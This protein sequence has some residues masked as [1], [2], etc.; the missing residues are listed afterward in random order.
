MGHTWSMLKLSTQLVYSTYCL[1]KMTQAQSTSQACN[2]LAADDLAGHLWCRVLWNFLVH[3]HFDCSSSPRGPLHGL[4]WNIPASPHFSFSCSATVPSVW[5]DLG[6]LLLRMTSA[7]P[8]HQRVS[9]MGPPGYASDSFSQSAKGTMH[10]EST[11]GT[12]MHKTISSN[13]EVVV[14]SNL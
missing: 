2:T 9:G 8:S 10:I 5:K 1:T 7:P 4:P 14:P 12:T 3:S 11:Q 13:L 6:L